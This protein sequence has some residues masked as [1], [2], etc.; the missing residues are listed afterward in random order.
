MRHPPSPNRAAA[1]EEEG[2][3]KGRH[4]SWPQRDETVRPPLE[5]LVR[6][7]AAFHRVISLQIGH[8]GARGVVVH[9]S[10][11]KKAAKYE[12]GDG[13]EQEEA[14]EKACWQRRAQARGG[15]SGWAGLVAPSP[16]A[17]RDGYLHSTLH[18]QEQEEGVRRECRPDELL[19]L[20]PVALGG[21]SQ[22]DEAEGGGEAALQVVD[23]TANERIRPVRT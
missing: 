8:R 18:G 14:Q 6:R 10:I 20:G 23:R 12:R 22:V 3:V 5:P 1:S 11:T 2:Q 21:H 4:A 13:G 9:K 16:A 15:E 19:E 17:S 7:L